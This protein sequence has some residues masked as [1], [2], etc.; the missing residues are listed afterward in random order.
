MYSFSFDGQGAAVS[1]HVLRSACILGT[2][3]WGIRPR[4]H[5]AGIREPGRTNPAIGPWTSMPLAGLGQTARCGPRF[6]HIDRSFVFLEDASVAAVWDDREWS[7][8]THMLRLSLPTAVIRGSTE[9]PVIH[10]RR[11]SVHGFRT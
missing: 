10:A 1:I 11:M 2:S 7:G 8:P 3:L 6:R 5:R 4:G 9:S